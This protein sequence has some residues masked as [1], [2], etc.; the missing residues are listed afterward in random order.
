MK[1]TK[2]FILLLMQP[3]T[4]WRL[5]KCLGVSNFVYDSLLSQTATAV[6][7]K[8]TYQH[9]L[10]LRVQLQLQVSSIQSRVFWIESYD[11]FL[12]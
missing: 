6:R 10:A 8:T 9:S 1:R 12:L 4:G 5:S 7:R 2:Y 3:P 11:R